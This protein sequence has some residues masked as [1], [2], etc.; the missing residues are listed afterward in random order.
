MSDT[1]KLQQK[2]ILHGA[3]AVTMEIQ[4]ARVRVVLVRSLEC[5]VGYRLRVANIVRSIST[6][7]PS[8]AYASA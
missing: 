1:K 7:I 3:Y 5:I 6:M 8:A 4:C 2:V